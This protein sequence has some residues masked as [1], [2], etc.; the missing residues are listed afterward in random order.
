[1]LVQEPS[2]SD[3]E[4]SNLKPEELIPDKLYHFI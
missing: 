4:T 3:L 1:M 2:M